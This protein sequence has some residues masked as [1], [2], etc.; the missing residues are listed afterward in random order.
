MGKPNILIVEDDS[1]LRYLYT[2][3]LFSGFE[4][5]T[6]E[7]GVDALTE[8]LSRKPDIIIT[9][10]DLPILDGIKFIQIVKRDAECATVPI[11]VISGASQ[12]FMA[13]ASDAGAAK[14]MPKPI[15]PTL[16]LDEL[17]QMLPEVSSH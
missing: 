2:Y 6:A 13:E 3:V 4:V 12:E 8:V 11:I 16:L 14:V 7:N 5:R 1:D 10:I 15:D 17:L 9:D